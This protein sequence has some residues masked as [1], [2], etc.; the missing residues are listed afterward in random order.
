M[1]ARTLHCSFHQN[2]W[3]EETDSRK[4]IR[5]PYVRRRC[6]ERTRKSVSGLTITCANSC[7]W[8]RF[9]RGLGDI[10]FFFLCSKNPIGI[11][12]GVHFESH[13]VNLLTYT[14][15]C[16]WEHGDK[17]KINCSNQRRHKWNVGIVLHIKCLQW[18]MHTWI[19]AVRIIFAHTY[20]FSR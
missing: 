5:I 8:L 16:L 3:K 4:D 20:G 11:S 18:F 14:H 12:P 1:T 2:A 10:F 15:V 19:S 13:P 6:Y 9:V 17:I 7:G